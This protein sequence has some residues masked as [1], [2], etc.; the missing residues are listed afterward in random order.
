MLS[1]TSSWTTGGPAWFT[2]TPNHSCLGSNRIAK[3]ATPRHWEEKDGVLIVASPNN[4]G[5]KIIAAA[6]GPGSLVN[7]RVVPGVS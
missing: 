5:K 2:M 4:Q 6:G 1:R 3:L 7:Q